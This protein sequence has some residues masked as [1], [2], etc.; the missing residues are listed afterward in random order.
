MKSYEVKFTHYGCVSWKG[1]HFTVTLLRD[2]RSKTAKSCR[3]L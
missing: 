1:R 2:W 3:V